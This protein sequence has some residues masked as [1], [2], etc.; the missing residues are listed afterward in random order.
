MFVVRGPEDFGAFPKGAVLIARITNPA[1]TPLFYCACAVIT[2]SG[3]PLSHGVVTA[4]EMGKPAVMAV[5]GV[6]TAFSNGDMVEGRLARSG[7]RNLLT[8]ART[9]K[10]NSVARQIL[11]DYERRQRRAFLVWKCHRMCNLV[12]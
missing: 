7:F 9:I 6:L 11:L 4:R 8:C 10:P 1:W 12:S 5:R 3:G 2:E